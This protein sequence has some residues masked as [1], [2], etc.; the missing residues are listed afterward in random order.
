MIT[1]VGPGTPLLDPRLFHCRILAGR[2]KLIVTE[3]ADF[4]QEDLNEDDCMVLDGGDEVYVWIGKTASPEE[5]EQSLEM[6]KVS[7]CYQKQIRK[8]LTKLLFSAI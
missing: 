2:K 8:F 3:I 5:K 4:S 7:F 6:A 1:K